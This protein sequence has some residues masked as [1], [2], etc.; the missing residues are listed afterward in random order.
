MKNRLSYS[1]EVFFR[2]EKYYPF[3]EDICE[4]FLLNG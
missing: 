3:L 1:V 4:I 2:K